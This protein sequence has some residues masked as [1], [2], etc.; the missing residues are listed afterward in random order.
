MEETP[1]KFEQLE[2]CTLNSSQEPL[3]MT[4]NLQE[5]ERAPQQEQTLQQNEQQQHQE[6]LAAALRLLFVNV[7]T[8]V[9]SQLQGNSDLLQLIEKMNLRTA[10]DYNEFG[11]FAA[12]LR[13]FV[14]RLKL[15]NDS[16]QHYTQQIDEIEHEV[17]ELE[18]V[19]SMLDN[20]TGALEAKL[21]AAYSE[22]HKG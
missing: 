21:R 13:V 7:A 4:T 2:S 18:A 20:H 10:D 5:K 9:Q 22:R 14:E 15:K 1:S 8:L 16:F 11:D 3:E 17:T 6:P 12:G 19:I